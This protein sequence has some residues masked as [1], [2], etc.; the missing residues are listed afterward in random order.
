MNVE[1]QKR[2]LAWAMGTTAV[3]AV[4]AIGSLIGT[5]FTQHTWLFDVVVAAVVVGVISQVWLLVGALRDR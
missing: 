1:R 4:V 2:R 5:A 3:C